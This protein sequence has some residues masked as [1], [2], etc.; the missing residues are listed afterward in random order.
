MKAAA[1]AA[2][3]AAA[4]AAAVTA[5]QP[6]AGAA[7]A[8]GKKGA[9]GSAGAAS[10][11][12]AAAADTILPPKKKLVAVNNP[13]KLQAI[14]L[15][16]ILGESPACCFLAALAMCAAVLAKR[17]HCQRSNGLVPASVELAFHPL[18]GTFVCPKR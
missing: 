9:A 10:P 3:A 16:G 12:M 18:A 17:K 4:E 2:G 15:L 7:A 8:A 5:L 11:T 13:V 1:A 14:R 6:A